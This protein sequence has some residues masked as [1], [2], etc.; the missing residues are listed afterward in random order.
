G[1]APQAGP[2]VAFADA[3]AVSA[4]RTFAQSADGAV[5]WATGVHQQVNEETVV[6][7]AVRGWF[8]GANETAP[9]D[10]SLG[11]DVETYTTQIAANATVV[12]PTAMLDA[13]TA[14]IATLAR[15]NGAQ[16]AVQFVTRQP[17]GLVKEG[18]TPRRH[19]LPAPVGAFVTA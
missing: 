7:R 11:V 19:V 16:T 15:E 8:L 18:D 17:L 10:G 12:G 1:P 6:T 2:L 9:L 14:M 4:A 5:F 3:G 13:N